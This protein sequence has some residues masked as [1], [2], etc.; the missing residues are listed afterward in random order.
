[1]TWDRLRRNWRIPGTQYRLKTKS[2]ERRRAT[3]YASLARFFI[4]V[5]TGGCEKGVEPMVQ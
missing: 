5:K 3:R 2:H 1:L 4:G